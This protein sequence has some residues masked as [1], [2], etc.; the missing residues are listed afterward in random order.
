MYTTY[1]YLP[2]ATATQILDDLTLLMTGTVDKSTLSIGC[3]KNNT[4]IIATIPAG[5]TPVNISSSTTRIISAPIANDSTTLK[6][7]GFTI[8]AGAVYLTNT[9]YESYNS[10][11]QVG[12]NPTPVVTTA[13]FPRIS[14]GT[15]GTLLISSS[16]RHCLIASLNSDNIT[17]TPGSGIVEYTRNDPWNTTANGYPC[18]AYFT[19]STF[20]NTNTNGTVPNPFIFTPR[21]YNTSTGVD[22]VGLAAYMGVYSPM[23]CTTARNVFDQGVGMV[24]GGIS[25]APWNLGASTIK[26]PT[27]LLVPLGLARN[28]ENI[29][30][31]GGDISANCGIYATTIN[32]GA[33]LNEMLV[34]N[35][36]YVL[37]GSSTIMANNS[38][39]TSRFAIKKA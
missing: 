35:D 1:K 28:S 18:F 22:V 39:N 37:W 17:F 27:H 8:S 38:G 24:V 2:S 9:V 16:N 21:M 13:Y 29:S 33:P 3:D 19:M 6:Y 4:A 36:T 20:G 7:F 31:L 30:A 32:E 26:A 11:T 23:L 34:G 10:A 25:I 12:T 15:S 14:I 5:W